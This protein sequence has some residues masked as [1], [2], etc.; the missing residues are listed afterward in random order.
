MMQ[1][2]EAEKNGGEVDPLIAAEHLKTEEKKHPL[3]EKLENAK[4]FM[5]KAP[6]LEFLL[7]GI[8][9]SQWCFT[10]KAISRIKDNLQQNHLFVVSVKDS[11]VY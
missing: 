8:R 11:N 1:E 4:F 7:K 9:N 3:I 5:I 10:A 2:G 6:N